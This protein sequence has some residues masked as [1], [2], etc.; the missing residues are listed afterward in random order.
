MIMQMP[1]LKSAFKNLSGAPHAP[2]YC[3][4]PKQ[5][6]EPTDEINAPQNELLPLLLMILL[7]I[8]ISTILSLGNNRGLRPYPT[9]PVLSTLLIVAGGAPPKTIQGHYQSGLFMIIH[10][11]L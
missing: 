5:A 8:Y 11:V 4:T 1:T 3:R 10:L 7:L 9:V 2:Q 6:P